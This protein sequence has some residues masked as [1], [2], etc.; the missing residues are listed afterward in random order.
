MNAI[1]YKMIAFG[2]EDSPISA[3]RGFFKIKTNDGCKNDQ[4]II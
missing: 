4:L 3:I 1:K 2:N